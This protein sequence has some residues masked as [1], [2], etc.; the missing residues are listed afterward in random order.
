MSVEVSYRVPSEL[1]ANVTTRAAMINAANFVRDLWLSE[2]PHVSGEYARGLLNPKSV[3][4]LAGE[5]TVVNHAKHAKFCEYGHRAFN[6]GLAMLN[7]SSKTKVS[8]D[9]SR[10][11][12]IRIDSKG[13]SRIRSAAVKGNVKK[14][15]IDTMPL[16]SK[17]PVVRK[18]GG[19]AKYE[20]RKRLQKPLVAK[21]SGKGTTVTISEKAIRADPNKWRVPALPGK[22]LARKI[23]D[24]AEPLVKEMLRRAIEGE[25]LRYE[26]GHGRSP[27]WYRKTMPERAVRRSFVREVR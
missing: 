18:Y 6:I 20:Q 24:E 10:Y 3:R 21:S 26:R 8:K 5:I 15:F 2:S 13:K 9:G 27:T 7:N 1:Y 11:L 23:H 12:V 25:R 17:Y 19:I 14:A 22:G 4:V 16:G